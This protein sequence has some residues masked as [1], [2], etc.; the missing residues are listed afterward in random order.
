MALGSVDYGLIGVVGCL[1]GFI[2]FLNSLMGAAVGRFY[3]FSVGAEKRSGSEEDG[4]DSCRR[5]FNAAVTIHTVIP[6]VLMAIGYPIGEWAVENYLTIPPDRVGDCIWVW[7]YTCV[8]CFVGMVSIP[9]KAMYEA[10]Q[11]IAELTVYS[12]ATTTINVFVMYYMVSHPGVW[13]TRY[14]A[15]VCLQI[16]IPEGIIAARAFVKYPEC[17]IVREYLWDW[18]RFV[19]LAKYGFS[20]V[21][22]DLATMISWQGKIILVNKYMGPVF[23]AATTVGSSVASKANT[24]SGALSTA[25]WPAIANK[26]GEGDLVELKRLSFMTCR[27]G[28][29]LVLVFAIPLALEIREVLRLWLVNPPDFTAEICVAVLVSSVLLK[30]TDGYWM[31]ILGVG[32]GVFKYSWITGWAGV[33]LVLVAWMLFALGCGM[34]SIVVAMVVS[35]LLTACAR[36]YLGRS[37]VRF[38]SIYWLRSTLLPIAL[39][40][41]LSVSFGLSIRLFL[42]ASLFRV[43]VTG[44]TVELVLLPLIWLF[45]L[46]NDEKKFVRER[47]L[48]RIMSKFVGKQGG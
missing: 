45:V 16:A 42:S 12:F 31:A 36:I 27:L 32:K 1:S 24:L 29:V 43:I 6:T 3:A 7:R 48:M 23:N 30:M 37:L 40:T 14:M 13:L 19:E 10:K 18:N 9:F 41:V 20:R 34:W 25:F 4:I 33:S 21:W 39:I 35:N 2:S 5:W 22:S 11:E 15:W 17:R 8:T 44:C 46:N 47:L 38:S 28:A 26:A